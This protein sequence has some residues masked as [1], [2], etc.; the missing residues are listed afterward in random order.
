MSTGSLSSQ[1]HTKFVTSVLKY[2]FLLGALWGGISI[3]IVLSIPGD[4]KNAWLFGFSKTRL[5]LLLGLLVVTVALAGLGILFWRKQSW[6]QSV[7]Q[8]LCW[9]SLEFGYLYPSL[10]LAFGVTV[11]IPYFYMFLTYPLEG[12]YL[13]IFPIILFLT[14]LTV[15]TFI[16]LTLIVRMNREELKFDQEDHRTLWIDPWKVVVILLSITFVFILANLSNNVIQL[17]G[18]A[19]GLERYTDKLDMDGEVNP[20][21]YFNSFLLL[22]PA[23]L[24]GFIAWMRGR[25][26]SY[27]WSWIILAAIFIYLSVD[28]STKL[29]ELLTKPLRDGLNTGGILLYAWVIVAIPILIGL[30]IVF[31]PFILNLP[32]KTK[33]LFLLAAVLYIGGALGFEMLAGVF[34]SH[35]GIHNVFY[36]IM[37]TV[38]ETL[39]L[40][41]LIVLI[42]ALL[43]FIRTNFQGQQIRI[44][45]RNS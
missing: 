12:F 5:V 21:T 7:A 25:K 24:M 6:T 29:H 16:A 39:E 31:L 37:S 11:L 35:F 13:R 15:Q 30:G 44:S 3:L 23:L 45:G 26:A 36:L 18:Y 1:S 10:T 2:Y 27:H 4:P 9:L 34:I 43:D 17:S 14:L 40:T 38:E 19:P 20:P 8:K 33:R 22:L 28:E 42:Y 41:G 32:R